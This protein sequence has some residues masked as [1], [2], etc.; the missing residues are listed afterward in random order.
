MTAAA[1]AA[2]RPQVRDIMTAAPRTIDRNQTLDVADA[3]IS[4]SRIRHLPVVEGGQVVGV[5]SQRDL[6]QAAL[7]GTLGYGGLGRAR[8]LKTIAVKEVMSE[9]PVTVAAGTDV[10]AAAALMI[11]NRIGCLPVLDGGVLVGV[12]TETDLIRHAYGL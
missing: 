8:L 11:S 12:V 9:P 6:F 4:G 2:G 5:L 1:Q 10:G 3:M 7:A